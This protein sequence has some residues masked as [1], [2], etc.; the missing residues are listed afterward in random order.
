MKHGEASTIIP[1]EVITYAIPKSC[2]LK[3]RSRPDVATNG[4]RY[5]GLNVLE[6]HR[7]KRGVHFV[8]PVA[9]LMYHL[10]TPV[11]R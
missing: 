4:Q 5:G 10:I 2:D 3:A 1:P 7:V 9:L 6:G 11:K 8:S